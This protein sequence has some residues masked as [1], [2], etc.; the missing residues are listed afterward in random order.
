MKKRSDGRYQKSFRVNGRLYVVYGHNM[1]ELAE[2]ER[3]KRQEI[4]AGLEKRKE[5]TLQQ[6][7]YNWMDARHGH[8]KEST[9]HTQACQYNQ[10]ANVIISTT[11]QRL[12][13]MK[14]IDIQTDDIREVQQTLLKTRKTQTVNDAIAVLSHIF[15]DAI[16][17]RKCSYN[18]CKAVK[19][20]KR[21]EEKARDTH[22]RALT[23]DETRAFLAA[24]KGSHY[25]N[26]YRF[27][28]ATG[29][30]AGEI[31]ALLPA[32]I[33]KDFIHIRRTLTRCEN[34]GYKIGEDAKT[35][36]GCRDIPLNERIREILKNQRAYNAML[37][38][39]KVI[40]LE[41]AKQT[42]IFR[43]TEG[44]LLM[45]TPIDREIKRICK[46]AGNIEY[47][48]LHSL[49]ATFATRAIESGINPRTLQELLGHKDFKITMNLYG[50]VCNDT[51]TD[52]MQAINY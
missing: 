10:M 8:I 35:K 40:S 46:A 12:A 34:G 51:L 37:Y 22:H 3:E 43:A 16:L 23:K 45:S 33:D 15:H 32:D 38:G 30:R 17:E 28:L 27:A 39:N 4:A 11:G 50:H 18:P 9:L 20:L 21:T 42:P 47:F 19:P 6:F 25:Y 44:G 7:Y 36:A 49:R 13:D 41:N 14:M 31:A 24:A 29:M 2:K 5:P 52:A 48:T 26:V 1:T